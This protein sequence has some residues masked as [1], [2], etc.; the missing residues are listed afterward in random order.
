MFVGDGGIATAGLS[1]RYGWEL[2][3]PGGQFLVSVANG[4]R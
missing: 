1:D 3:T 4:A 2:V